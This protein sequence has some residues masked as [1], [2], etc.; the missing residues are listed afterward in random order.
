VNYSYLIRAIEESSLTKK[1]LAAK[2]GMHY[3]GLAYALKNKT[4]AVDT[5]EKICEVLKI[6]IKT[7]FEDKP[8][9][10]VSADRSKVYVFELR[11][12]DTLKLDMD[13]K[14]LE[15]VKK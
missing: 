14:I 4:L 6:D 5:L 15:I 10:I 1:S 13:N 2:I 9:K 7:L 3:N 12:S 11:D 8:Q